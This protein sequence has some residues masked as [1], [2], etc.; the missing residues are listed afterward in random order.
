[1]DVPRRRVRDMKMHTILNFEEVSDLAIRVIYSVII[2]YSVMR[3][4]L[5]CVMMTKCVDCERALCG[6]DERC[7][8]KECTAWMAAHAS[9]NTLCV[10]Y[11]W[12]S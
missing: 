1:M 2:I 9:A 4:L 12:E 6:R 3:N 5:R 11:V 8:M 10:H 7:L